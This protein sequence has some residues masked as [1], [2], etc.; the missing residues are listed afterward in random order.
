MRQDGE[1]TVTLCGTTY[2]SG[3]WVMAAAG[4]VVV[5]VLSR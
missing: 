5:E 1:A 2:S 4:D 3:L